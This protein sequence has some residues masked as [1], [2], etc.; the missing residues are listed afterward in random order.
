MSLC[1]CALKLGVLDPPG[2]G[3]MSSCELPDVDAGIL[4]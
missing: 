4:P 3:F 1:G 2:A